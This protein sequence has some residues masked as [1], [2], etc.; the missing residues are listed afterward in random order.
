MIHLFKRAISN[1]CEQFL[2]WFKHELTINQRFKTIY[3]QVCKEGYQ[4]LVTQWNL[5]SSHETR[6]ST[7]E[8][9]NRIEMKFEQN[10]LVLEEVAAKEII[11]DLYEVKMFG[12]F[13]KAFKSLTKIK[14]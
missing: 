10:M 13:S 9:I 8:A 11:Q 14:D 1:E 4:W 3:L 12:A 5:A 2:I 6:I 7:D